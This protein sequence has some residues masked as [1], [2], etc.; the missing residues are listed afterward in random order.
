MTTIATQIG[1][2]GNFYHNIGVA[3]GVTYVFYSDTS[4]WGDT[5]YGNEL[6]YK[7]SSDNFTVKKQIT[8]P[9]HGAD[10]FHHYH[11]GLAQGDDAFC[12]FAV[13]NDAPALETWCIK[14]SSSGIDP[15]QIPYVDPGGGAAY[16]VPQW[17]F[18]FTGS[19]II[20]LS[21]GGG[22]LWDYGNYSYVY[23]F[24][25]NTLYEVPSG[26]VG[27]ENYQG[28]IVPTFRYP[29]FDSQK[30][31]IYT[32]FVGLD[33]NNSSEAPYELEYYLIGFDCDTY[34][35]FAEYIFL[36]GINWGE[37]QNNTFNLYKRLRLVGWVH[38]DRDELYL[39]ICYYS[40][41]EISLVPA[42]PNYETFFTGSDY[43]DLVSKCAWFQQSPT[44]Y[45]D[46]YIYTTFEKMEWADRYEGTFIYNGAQQNRTTCFWMQHSTD[47]VWE[48]TGALYYTVMRGYGIYS[49]YMGLIA[50]R[51]LAYGNF[52][53]VALQNQDCKI[54]YT[55]SDYAGRWND[56]LG[57]STQTY[58]LKHA[59]LDLQSPPPVPFYTGKDYKNQ[60]FLSGFRLYFATNKEFSV[61]SKTV[62]VYDSLTDVLLF[63]RTILADKWYYEIQTTDA[64]A[65]DTEY[66]FKAF[67][68]DVCGRVGNK[69]PK[70][71][72]T[73]REVPLIN[74]V[75]ISDEQFPEIVINASMY[76]SLAKKISIYFKQ[77]GVTKAY[78]ITLDPYNY[79][80]EFTVRFRPLEFTGQLTADT[81]DYTVEILNEYDR[82]GSK[83]GVKIFT[84]ALPAAPLASYALGKGSTTITMNKICNI[85]RDNILLIEGTGLTYKDIDC[86]LGLVHEYK[87][88]YYDN[89]AESLPVTLNTTIYEW[90]NPN[91]YALCSQSL[92]MWLKKEVGMTVSPSTS[93][94][95]LRVYEEIEINEQRDDITIEMEMET[96]DYII[97][98]ETFEDI[99]YYFKFGIYSLGIKFLSCVGKHSKN[100]QLYDVFMTAVRV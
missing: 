12:I 29:F 68:T 65:W 36:P 11:V 97:F 4:D 16:L 86:A 66:Y 24:D 32:A 13:Y 31:L 10:V 33:P 95:W 69:S 90:G 8:V 83:T 30:N 14:F 22:Y 71:H 76:D 50:P 61:Y 75:T 96:A 47:D 23:D 1:N 100:K 63:S 2:Y 20:L 58:T 43:V 7:D 56:P 21:G 54:D 52:F 57:V 73:T 17:A 74:S 19:G 35:F 79:L 62:E 85:Y 59:E 82:V 6:S 26:I 53:S 84:F 64:L 87:V 40:F 92:D 46:W 94:N 72:F 3:D 34:Q 45:N 38:D 39:A 60:W 28:Q 9:G 5:P 27:L 25:L 37:V 91:H 99:L 44:N 80:D 81:Y 18:D 41:K 77:L 48:G 93:A 88:V 42:T 70:K 78:S 67:Y 15:K 51:V 49:D 55:F 98:R 89:M